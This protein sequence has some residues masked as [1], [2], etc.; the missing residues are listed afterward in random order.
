MSDSFWTG[1][2]DAYERGLRKHYEPQ[3]H[4]LRAR[5]EACAD[6][7]SRARLESELN[8]IEVEYR[9]KLDAIGKLLF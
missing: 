1:G 7:A 6:D 4:E 8:A 5:C 3:L 9:L 2:A